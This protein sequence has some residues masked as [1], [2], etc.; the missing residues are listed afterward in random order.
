MSR[1]KGISEELLGNGFDVRIPTLG[2]SMFPFIKT[3]DRITVSPEK[4][5]SIGDI[6]L[7]KREGMMICHRLVRVF[8]KAGIKYYQTR[9]DSFFHLDVPVT[10]DQ[11]LGKVVRIERENGSLPRKILLLVHPALRFGRLNALVISALIR[12][13]AILC[14]TKSH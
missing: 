7:F 4:H 10:A 1:I 14:S 3:G 8:E 6:I 13:K 5:P 12:I 11:I 9:G 2:P